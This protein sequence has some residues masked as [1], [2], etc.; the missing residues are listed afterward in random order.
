MICNDKERILIKT[1]ESEK[2]PGKTLEQ[3]PYPVPDTREINELFVPESLFRA[4]LDSYTC[5]V[6]WSSLGDR[7][8]VA[9]ERRVHVFNDVLAGDSSSVSIKHA[10]G[11]YHLEFSLIF[12]ISMNLIR[13]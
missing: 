11:C 5:G 6:K 12:H 9:T 4:N 2:T 1:E 8:A 7:F 13:P 3:S 10:E